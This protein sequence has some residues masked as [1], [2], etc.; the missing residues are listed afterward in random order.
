MEIP[1]KFH[2]H[3]EVLSAKSLELARWKE[4]DAYEEVAIEDQHVIS[5]RWVVTEK[6]DGKV[7]SRLV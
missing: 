7:K 4:F 1:K 2:D 5:T 3:P 6:E